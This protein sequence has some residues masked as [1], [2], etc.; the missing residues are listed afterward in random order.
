MHHYTIVLTIKSYIALSILIFCT[1]VLIN[2]YFGTTR[3]LVFRKYK[4]PLKLVNWD[5]LL[6]NKNVDSQ[7]LVLNNIIL[8]IFRNLEP[9]K[10]ITFDDKDPVWMNEN[11]RSKIKAQNKFYQEYVDKGKQETDFCADS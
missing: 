5:R 1:H 8:N 11:I 4:K 3:R 9:N 10:Y 6:D 2:V 7:V